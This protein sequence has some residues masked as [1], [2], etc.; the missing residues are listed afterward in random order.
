MSN[1]DTRQAIFYRDL[2]RRWQVEFIDH[3]HTFGGAFWQFV[4]TF[5]WGT[6]ADSTVY[7]SENVLQ[8]MESWIERA[9][10]LPDSVFATAY[11]CVPEEW[12]D[13]DADALQRLIEQLIR[14]RIILHRIIEHAIAHERSP[15][16]P[17]GSRP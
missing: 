12:I 3:G 4:N 5:G 17:L 8:S 7:R 14:R 11:S 16:H 2:S 9:R 6:F 13:A 15:F 10:T 1:I